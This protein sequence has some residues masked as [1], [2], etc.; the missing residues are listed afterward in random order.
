LPLLGIGAK[1]AICALALY[2]IMPILRN[3]LAVVQDEAQNL[4]AIGAAL[5][6]TPR[7]IL[8]RI[9]IP[10]GAPLLVSGL[11]TAAVWSVGTATLS[12]FIG[13][14][15]LGEFINRGISLLDPALMLL[16]AVPAAL[17]ALG[18]DLVLGALE[19]DAR[20]WR[21]G[22][23]FPKRRWAGISVLLGL[24]L[25]TLGILHEAATPGRSAAAAPRPGSPQSPIRIGTKNFAEQ[26]VLGEFIAQYLEAH[27]VAVERPMRGFQSTELIHG[28]LVNGQIDLYVEYLGTAE[29]AILKLP[30]APGIDPMARVRDAYAKQ[31]HLAWLEGLGF[32]NTY[33]VVTRREVARGATSLTQF[34]PLAP[35][36][37]IGLNSEFVE[38][39][40]GF[41]A[42]E[43][44]YGLHFAQ[45]ET[46]DVGL[47]YA[48]L[49]DK[50]SARGG[51][52]TRTG[53]SPLGIL[54]PVCLPFHH[55]GGFSYMSNF[56]RNRHSDF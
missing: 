20:Q 16:G 50:Q 17:L 10:Q 3:T 29:E 32:S 30:P 4:A 41:P 36:L 54:S 33:A 53:I 13:A 45:V 9:K 12:A 34:V 35:Q 56:R 51:S 5:G 28:A 27:G 2:A 38:R 15:G 26:F 42:L 46:L 43:K 7:E 1:P 18:I 52:R 47:L 49:Q 48:A 31:F 37:R 22:N 21:T 40:D 23:H 8:W 24:F 19:G 25:L 55:S 14:G 39:A 11:R 6:L 44:T